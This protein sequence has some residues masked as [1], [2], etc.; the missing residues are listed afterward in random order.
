MNLACIVAWLRLPTQARHSLHACS[1]QA[2]LVVFAV[3]AHAQAPQVQLLRDPSISR[4]HIVFSYAGNIWRVDRDGG[5]P[6]RLTSSGHDGKPFLSPD[7]SQI[8]FTGD[9]NANAGGSVTGSLYVISIDGGEPRQLTHH[10]ADLAALGWTPDGRR[11]LFSSRRA[12]SGLNQHSAVQLFTVAREGGM[13]TPLPLARAAQGSFSSDQARLAYVPIVPWQPTWKRYRGGQTLPIWIARLADSSIETAIPRDNSNDFNPMWVGD[14]IYFLSDRAGPVTLF[15]YDLKSRQVRQVLRNDGLDLK[16]ASA[17]QDAVVY[18]QFG[19]LHLLDL[20]SG[21]DHALDI[22]PLCDLPEVQPHFA[23]IDPT[24]IRFASLSPSGARVLFGVHGEILT[25]PI[26]NG[27]IRNLTQSTDAVERDPAWSPDGQ[28]IAYFSDESGEYALHIR[29]QRGLQSVLKIDLGNP[30]TFYYSPL[31]SP[32]SRKIAYTDKRLN[33]WYVD[34]EN[35]IPVHVDT[36]LYVDFAHSLQMAWSPDGRWIAYTKQL[37]SHLHAVF[38]YSLDRARS[39]QLTD[40][41][42]DALYVAFDK[43]GKY[44]YFTASTDVAL[45]TEQGMNSIQH[46]V[47]RNVY[48]ILLNSHVASPL[49]PRSEEEG[50]R[51]TKGTGR[52]G[53]NHEDTIRLEVDVD[54]VRQRTLA[55]PIPARNYY[56]LLVGREGVIFLIAG[57]QV[58]PFRFF[59]A[60]ATGEVYKFEMGSRRTQ[61]IVSDATVFHFPFSGEYVPS[62]HLSFDG[63][64]MLYA[65]HGQWFIAQAEIPVEGPPP[66]AH[67]TLKLEP[68]EIYV[69]PRAEW[70]HMFYQ[71]WRDEREFFYD[72]GLHG[73][74]LDVVRKR[75]EPYLAGLS[76]RDDLDYLFAEMLGNLAVGHVWVSD[77]QPLDPKREKT[78]LL[79]ADYDILNGRYRV[80]RIYSRDIWNPELAAP[81]DEPGVDVRVGE[82]LLAV[83]GRDVHPPA[84]I[85]RFFAGTAGKRVSLTVGPEPDGSRSRNI[86]VIP[87]DDETALR[88]YAWAENNRRKVDELTGGQVAYIYL[89]NT[90][91]SGFTLFNRFYFAQAGKSAA[92][93]DDRYNHG[94]YIPDYIIDT[95]RRPLRNYWN[96]REGKDLT[97]PLVAIFGPKAMLI[98]EMAGSGGDALPWMFRQA[99]IGPLIG[100]RTWGGLVAVHSPDDLLDGG[101]V[102]TPDGAFYN[103]NG[104]WDVEGRGVMPDIDVED[105]PKA[106]REGRD[107]QLERA[108]DVMME[109]LRRDPPAPPPYHPPYPSYRQ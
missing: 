37:A 46:P 64:K 1:W 88:D 104:A 30:P 76:T 108:V 107:P 51:Q 10:P 80:N 81:L 109:S 61:Q 72:P 85:Y 36:D 32:D 5:N 83:N 82:Y 41:I 86:T 66:P 2:L 57:P 58:D 84:E 27:V 53:E 33:Y 106:A 70:K 50:G 93:I 77:P 87:I 89:P 55:L 91:S 67:G 49:A 23:K 65:R 94:G 78:G 75:Y 21:R 42:S 102:T 54:N 19:S 39:Y 56:G 11:I 7:G 62:L 98:N 8:A 3:G 18:E 103:L 95:L 69:D 13:A 25:A 79:G 73:L 35:K 99:G 90:A 17:T 40:G 34:L 9:F 29:D 26:E 47:T 59:S 63:E 71:V 31:W 22:R 52:R 74:N 6:H 20:K 96:M 24:R 100:K 16:S 105:D 4:I 92:I 68:L 38:I 12:T 15:S 44:L 14:S 43:G 101:A 97:T 60:D 28:S 48:V 45:S